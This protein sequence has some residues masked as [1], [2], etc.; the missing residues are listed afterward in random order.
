MD[1]WSRPAARAWVSLHPAR[2]VRASPRP[3][4]GHGP[5]GARPSVGWRLDDH[6]R[7]HRRDGAPAAPSGAKH[8]RR[9]PAA[10]TPASTRWVGRRCRSGMGRWSWAPAGE[11]A[12][13]P[14]R[15]AGTPS[16]RSG[17]AVEC[18][19]GTAADG[20]W[21]SR[22]AARRACCRARWSCRCEP[23]HR[24]PAPS[25]GTD[26]RHRPPGACL[27]GTRSCIRGPSRQAAAPSWRHPC[28]IWMRSDPIREAPQPLQHP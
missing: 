17:R 2:R 8:V 14:D 16:G 5:C 12:R 13:A 23:R 10:C 26:P 19:A 3:R 27:S 7:R 11:C 15:H 20:R 24:R 25:P 28:C 21:I 22:G 9:V 6:E 1:A 4:S 18:S